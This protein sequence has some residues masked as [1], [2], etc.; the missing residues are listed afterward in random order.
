MQRVAAP[1]QALPG[2]P[3]V[4]SAVI[5]ELNQDVGARAACVLSVDGLEVDRAE[6]IWVD[7]GGLVSCA[8][9]HTFD[10]IGTKSVSV[11]AANVAPSDYDPDNNAAATSIVVRGIAAFDY[12]ELRAGSDETRRGSHYQD[13][14]TS[15]NG[16]IVYGRDYESNTLVTQWNQAID[17]YAEVRQLFDLSATQLSVTEST[18]GT[19]TRA[20]HLDEI[21]SAPD[22][23]VSR[24]AGTEPS[25]WLYIC[26]KNRLD[27]PLTTLTY[28]NLVG[29]VT[30]FSA[31]YDLQWHRGADGTSTT[32]ASYSWNDAGGSRSGTPVRWGSS[33]TVDVTLASL[34]T[35]FQ[36]PLTIPLNTQ[37]ISNSTPWQCGEW[38]GDWGSERFCGDTTD[39]RILMGGFTQIGRSRQ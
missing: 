10:S 23:C 4:I 37:T 25:L 39:V 32:D 38:E 9:T 11:Q 31:G 22:G 12:Y 1:A 29:E 6:G 20:F 15:S 2:T 24:Y 28:T 35:I 8:F 13:W 36:G 26:Q 34:T 33:Y 19:L 21:A 5:A 16:N 7:A 14:S 30:Y 17:Y 27:G 3:I 18:D